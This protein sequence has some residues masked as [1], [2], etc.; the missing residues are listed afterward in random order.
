MSMKLISRLL[1][2]LKKDK[3]TNKGNK[4]TVSNLNESQPGEEQL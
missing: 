2:G 1:E 3:E 4:T